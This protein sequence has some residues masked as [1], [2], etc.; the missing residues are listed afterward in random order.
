MPAL[1]ASL[2]QRFAPHYAGASRL[3]MPALRAP[4]HY[5]YY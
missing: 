5:H 2:C 4:A 1:R 3:T